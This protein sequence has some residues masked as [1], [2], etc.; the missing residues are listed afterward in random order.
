MNVSTLYLKKTRVVK[1][2]F[3]KEKQKNPIYTKHRTLCFYCE[4]TKYSI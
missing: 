4:E 1:N 3:V 2:Q